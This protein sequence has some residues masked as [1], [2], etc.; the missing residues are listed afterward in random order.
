M[1]VSHPNKNVLI[2]PHSIEHRVW[3]PV[4]PSFITEEQIHKKNPNGDVIPEDKGHVT[5]GLDCKDTYGN[6]KSN[7]TK[8]GNSNQNH[9]FLPFS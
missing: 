7:H 8:S 5:R 6:R 3:L 2:V 4:F 1:N 9:G